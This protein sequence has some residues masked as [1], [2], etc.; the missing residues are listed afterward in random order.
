MDRFT[1]PKTNGRALIGFHHYSTTTV[2][3]V[4][5]GW[6]CQQWSLGETML[7][8]LADRIGVNKAP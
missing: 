4:D 5:L 2:F 1:R 7:A 6:V 3:K 8:G